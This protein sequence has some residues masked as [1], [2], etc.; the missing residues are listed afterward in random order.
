L[1]FS[2]L[3]VIRHGRAYGPQALRDFAETIRIRNL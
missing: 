1:V 3:P 2:L